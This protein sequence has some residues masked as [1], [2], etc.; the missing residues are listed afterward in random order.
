MTRKLG[1]IS[2]VDCGVG[3]A[4]GSPKAKRCGGCQAA[5]KVEYQRE[6]RAKN[7][8]KILDQRRQYRE[9]NKDFIREGRQ[10]HY[11]ANRDSILDR[12]RQWYEA[13]REQVLAQQREYAEANQERLTERR[14]K[15]YSDNREEILKRSEAYRAANRESILE[16]KRRYREENPEYYRDYCRENPDVVRARNARR[17]V[18]V[19]VNMTAEDRKESVEYRKVLA[20]D[21]CSYCGQFSDEMH[22]DHI[23]PLAKGGTD[24]WWN[25]TNSCATCNLRKNDKPLIDFLVVL[26]D[27]RGK[28]VQ[29]TN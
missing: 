15:Y 13:N 4:S 26:A 16:S 3:F 11:A 18:R 10:R 20:G 8:E 12:Q 25:L 7:R 24:H 17:R 23:K 14:K 28:D 21:P 27:E 9:A 5:F 19:A 29:R 22:V 1:E 6:Y 2:C